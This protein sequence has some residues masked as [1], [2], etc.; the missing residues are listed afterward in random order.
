[1]NIDEL[2]GMEKAYKEVKSFCEKIKTDKKDSP[3]HDG[4]KIVLSHVIWLCNDNMSTIEQN[5]DGEIE[6]MYQMMEHNKAMND[7]EMIEWQK[8]NIKTT[9]GEDDR[10]DH[11]DL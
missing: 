6:R 2:R 1:M 10:Q 8:E 7:P 11:R 9:G 3:V 4:A 5:I